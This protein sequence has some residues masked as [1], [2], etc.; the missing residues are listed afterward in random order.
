MPGSRLETPGVGGHRTA[1][2]EREEVGARVELAAGRLLGRHVRGRAHRRTGH[3]HVRNGPGLDGRLGLHRRCCGR[4]AVGQLGEAEIEDLQVIAVADEQVRRLDVA[5]DDAAR[6]RRLERLGDLDPEVYD[7]LDRQRPLLDSLLHR[8]TLEQ[9]HDDE[10]AAVL[11]A[12]LVDRADVRMGQGG[13]EPRFALEARQP[14]RLGVVF[15][16]Q[17]LDRDLAIETEILPSVDDT[18]AALAELVEHAIMGNDRLSHEW[19]WS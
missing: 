5:V 15:L 16:A 14:R 4:P 9:F 8:Q 7:L 17:E 12:E 2:P 6:V 11:L 13:G 19:S 10:G 1:A 3:G 18:H